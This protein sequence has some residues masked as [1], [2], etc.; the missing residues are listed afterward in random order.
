MLDM[1]R[2][3]VTSQ[4]PL[5]RRRLFPVSSFYTACA[6][7]KETLANTVTLQACIHIF[8]PDG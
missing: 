7:R 1:P 2:A 3:E 4:K 5:Q 6:E 8:V